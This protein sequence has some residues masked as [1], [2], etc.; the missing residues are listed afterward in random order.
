MHFK[1]NIICLLFFHWPDSENMGFSSGKSLTRDMKREGKV[2]RDFSGWAVSRWMPLVLRCKLVSGSSFWL[3][4]GRGP[5]HLQYSPALLCYSSGPNKLGGL[6][7]Q[8]RPGHNTCLPNL[9][10]PLKVTHKQSCLLC[11]CCVES[12]QPWT[13]F[14]LPAEIFSLHFCR[15]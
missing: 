3:V 7:L 8:L 6:Q 5:G 4:Q 9:V 11:L 10:C 1:S 12:G 2:Q 14:P 15:G 13:R